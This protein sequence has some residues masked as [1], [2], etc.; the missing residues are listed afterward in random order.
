[1]ADLV[2]AAARGK[3]VKPMQRAGF[4]GVNVQGGF[5]VD[6]EK[7]PDLSG[8]KK[9]QTYTEL[10]RNVSIAGASVRLF[11]NMVSKASWTV[12]PAEDSGAKGE[13]IADFVTSVMDDM[14]RPWSRIVK[15][16]ALFKV[17]GFSWQEWIAKKRDDGMIGFLDIESRAAQTITR[18]DVDE[19]GV[20]F[21][22]VQE[23]P[24]TYRETYIPRAKSIYIVEDSIGDSPE[25][26]GLLRHAAPDA[27]RLQIYERLEGTGFENDLR[28]IPI[29][30]APYS[31]LQEKVDS[32]EMTAA[33]ASSV[34]SNIEGFVKDHVRS[35]ATGL[36]LDSSTYT[37][38]GDTQAPSSAELW[39]VDLL[40]SSSSSQ[41]EAAAS[42]N[43]LTRAIARLFGTEGMLLGESGAGSMALSKDKS[44][45]FGLIVDGTLVEVAQA[46][47]KDLLGPLALMN[48]WD[49]ELMPKLKTQKMQHR[50]ASELTDVLEGLSRAGAP[51]D[52]D[53]DAVNVVRDIVGF[54][55]RETIDLD[56]DASL[57]R[58][59]A[60][61]AIDG[62]P[63][64]SNA[65]TAIEDADASDT[66]TATASADADTN[67]TKNAK[68]A[69]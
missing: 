30:R 59:A 63:A 56:T 28:G 25:G 22:V 16:S 35:S 64:A 53:D 7:N 61:D 52:P 44:N 40:Q 67:D 26:D 20:I 6:N 18:W 62:S 54:P 4:S 60:A 46:Y 32:G 34:T 43:R 38:I 50:D 57:A 2:N 51:L 27:Q 10:L 58:R 68:K 69:R 21:G 47:E 66:T 23:S 36:V 9:F 17:M 5:I 41:A 48:G 33:A 19:A 55:K 42:I 45:S 12:E 11:L 3:R 65:T 24:Q 39:G 29:G 49:K 15:R 13:E 1:M 14:E 37:A 31:L 8:Q